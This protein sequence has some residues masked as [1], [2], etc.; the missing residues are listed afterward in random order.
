MVLP[1]AELAVLLSNDTLEAV[2]SV[3]GE[4]VRVTVAITPL[5]M[6]LL[7]RPQSTQLEFPA[8]LLH[9]RLFDAAVPWAPTTTLIEEKSVVE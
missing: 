3:D 7:F 1:A 2:L 4:I 6:V 8:V 5:E 9:V